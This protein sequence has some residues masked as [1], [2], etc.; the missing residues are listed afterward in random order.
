LDSLLADLE[1]LFLNILKSVGFGRALQLI[2]I[3]EKA[4]ELDDEGLT[5][6]ELSF[7]DE[8]DPEFVFHLQEPRDEA[9]QAKFSALAEVMRRRINACSKGLF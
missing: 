6:I 9:K 7:A 4:L 3:V 1:T 8:D 5:S 2:Q